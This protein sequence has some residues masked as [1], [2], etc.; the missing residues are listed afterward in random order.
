MRA[1]LTNTV[2]VGG[3]IIRRLPEKG[4][5]FYKVCGFVCDGSRY[6]TAS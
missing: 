5:N 3:A 4:V 2:A 6:M 1:L